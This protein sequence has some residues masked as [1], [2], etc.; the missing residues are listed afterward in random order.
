MNDEL[1]IDGG[2]PVIDKQIPIA[3][4]DVGEEEIKAIS[5]VVKSKQISR[6]SKVSKVEPQLNSYL[7]CKDSVIMSNGSSALHLAMLSLD[8][9]KGSEVIV[10]SFT[11]VAT[12]FTPI[13]C[14][15]KPVFADID[16][17]SFNISPDSIIEKITPKTKAIIPV[18]FAGRLCD[19]DNI[20]AIAEEH[21][22]KIVEDAA[23]AIGLSH[24]G[25]KVG[26]GQNLACFSFFATKNITSAEGGAVCSDNTGLTSKIRLMKAHSV[27][28]FPR[29]KAPGFYD[30]KDIGFNYHI[31]NLHLAMLESQL[32]KMDLFN[33]KRRDN[34]VLLSKHLRGVPGIKPPEIPPEHTFHLYNILLEKGS[35]QVSRE[36]ILEALL[37]EGVGAGLYY[38]PVHL[39]SYFRNNY[40]AKEGDLPVTEDV[41]ARTITLPLYPSLTGEHM[42]KITLAIE[43]VTSHFM[44]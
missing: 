12:A 25:K 4:P 35:F 30:V 19:M 29:P 16:E 31:S 15:L 2:T 27:E 43:K 6:G 11:F 34:A 41:A 14:G 1:A 20:K 38:P 26:S 32:R 40:S 33:K 3:S 28:R 37:A 42:E 36:K 24:D 17:H 9:P 8:L 23:H 13:Y 10:P 18:H 5:E 44:K 22:L 21:N 7:G 39:F